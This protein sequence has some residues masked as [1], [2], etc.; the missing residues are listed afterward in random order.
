MVI[1]NEPGY[2]KDGEW[3]I[4]IEGVDVIERRETRENFGGKGWLGFERITMCPI[5]RKLVDPPLLTIEEKDWLNEYHA[6]VLAK[7][8][9]VL[10]EMG[11]ERAGKWLERECQPL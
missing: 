2:Y 7:L 6:E 4:R 8:A 3:G 10:K 11:D 1:S 9:P 5:Q